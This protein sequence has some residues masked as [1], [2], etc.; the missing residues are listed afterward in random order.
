MIRKSNSIGKERER[1][2]EKK[3]R[4]ERLRNFIEIKA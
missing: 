3:F 4:R 1:E 2:R